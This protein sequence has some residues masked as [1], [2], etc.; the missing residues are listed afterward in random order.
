VEA[1]TIQEIHDDDEAE[2]EALAAAA[3]AAAA[4]RSRSNYSPAVRFAS[5]GSSPRR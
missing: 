3:E 5:R 2:K 1:K 4:A